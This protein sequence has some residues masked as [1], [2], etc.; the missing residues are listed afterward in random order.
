MWWPVCLQGFLVFSAQI[1][2]LYSGGGCFAVNGINGV[3]AAQTKYATLTITAGVPTL[4]LWDLAP[5]CVGAA[6][7]VVTGLGTGSCVTFGIFGVQLLAAST[8]TIQEYVH[9]GHPDCT[10]M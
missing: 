5:G 6:S 3:G 2:S 7:V 4:S 10:V 8:H 9:V 1:S